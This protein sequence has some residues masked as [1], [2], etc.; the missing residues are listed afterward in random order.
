MSWKGFMNK[1]VVGKKKGKDY[2]SGDLPSNRRQVFKFAYKQRWLTLFNT[3]FLAMLFVLPYILLEIMIYISKLNGGEKDVSQ[4]NSELLSI[5]VL[6]IP[7]MA[8]AGVGI[9]G[10]VYVIRKIC[11]DETLS[12]KKDF[13]RGVKTSGGQFAWIGAVL[14]VCMYVFEALLNAFGQSEGSFLTF[15]VIFTIYLLCIFILIVVIYHMGLCSMYNVGFLSSLKSA[16]LLTFKR[17]FF[18][19]L[20]IITAI[21]PI[22]IWFIIP[23][24]TTYF[25]GVTIL[26]FGGIS[27]SVLTCF[28]FTNKVFDDFINK[29]EYP[30]YVNKGLYLAGEKEYEK[31]SE[32]EINALAELLASDFNVEQE[33]SEELHESDGNLAES[34]ETGESD[35]ADFKANDTNEK[36]NEE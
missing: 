16:I 28:L 3:N 32:D 18:N 25:I 33:E 35:K 12:L 7:F 22:S 1:L 31:H 15:Y 20:M 13:F 36:G 23:I 2:S 27:F 14:A 29:N 24:T 5:T 10:M 8:L 21:L 17:M 11:W 34:Q 26:I 6:R 9:A 19:L 30:E 4:I